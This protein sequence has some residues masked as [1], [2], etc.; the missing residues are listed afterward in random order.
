MVVLLPGMKRTLISAHF[1]KKKPFKPIEATE[2]VEAVEA[3]E[4]ENVAEV[5]KS[6]ITLTQSIFWIFL[7]SKRQSR[8]LKSLRLSW[9]MRS[10]R[11]SGSLR[12]SNFK[13]R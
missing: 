1:W 12:Y 11:S 9:L 10:V 6:P 13:T 2:A 4:V 8:S 7:R 3:I 5:K